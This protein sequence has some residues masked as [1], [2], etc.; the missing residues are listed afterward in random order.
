MQDKFNR[1][2][3]YNSNKADILAVLVAFVITILAHIG[4]YYVIPQEFV[5]FGEEQKKYDD[6]KIEVLPPKIEKRMPDFIEANPYA[7]NEKLFVVSV[8]ICLDKIG[9]T[10]FDFWR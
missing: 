1:D 10:F 6:L 2:L 9:H 8:W 3:Y 4:A 7:N 5:K